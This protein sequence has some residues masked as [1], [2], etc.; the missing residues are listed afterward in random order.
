MKK[1][2]IATTV[3]ATALTAT[4]FAQAGQPQ[5][6][7]TAKP[8]TLTATTPAKKPVAK[9]SALRAYAQVIDPAVTVDGYPGYCDYRTYWG[10][11]VYDYDYY[12][13]Y[14]YYPFGVWTGP[15]Y[16]WNNTIPPRPDYSAGGYN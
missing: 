7:P 15:W 12:Y 13:A 5:K 8:T 1:I 3:L 16:Y 11:C 10:D 2:L 14:G 9:P 6:K 4:T